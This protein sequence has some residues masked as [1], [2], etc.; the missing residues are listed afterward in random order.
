MSGTCGPTDSAPGPRY[1]GTGTL[2][3][4]CEGSPTRVTT[5]TTGSRSPMRGGDRPGETK[6]D[7][8]DDWVDDD[9]WSK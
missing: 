4:A 5:Y 1:R 3:P 9:V 8:D 7:D 2:Y 6:D